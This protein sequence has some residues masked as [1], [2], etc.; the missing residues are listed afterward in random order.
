[1][2]RNQATLLKDSDNVSSSEHN[3]HSEEGKVKASSTSSAAA[4]AT[5]IRNP[6]AILEINFVHQTE[7]L[8]N[9]HVKS[10][11]GSNSCCGWSFYCRADSIAKLVHCVS[12]ESSFGW[13][14][15]ANG[16]SYA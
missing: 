15:A 5:L 9:L 2:L 12:S 8:S 1:M 13:A 3:T 16:D 10:S 6:F 7:K 14:A 4:P 11:T